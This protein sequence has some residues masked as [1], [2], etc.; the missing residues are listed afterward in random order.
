VKNWKPIL[1]G[2]GLFSVAIVAVIL[3]M[4]CIFSGH[5]NEVP[6]PAPA[7]APAPACPEF[8]D[9]Y[10]PGT[11]QERIECM[12]FDKDDP[13]STDPSFDEIMSECEFYQRHGLL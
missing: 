5:A 9:H 4:Y 7:P 6:V 12:C 13:P 2:F 8:T 3:G 11:P 1:L 10:E